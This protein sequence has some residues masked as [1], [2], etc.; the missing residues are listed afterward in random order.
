MTL[1]VANPAAPL[2]AAELPESGPHLLV[3]RPVSF[4]LLDLPGN[5]T[6]F[7]TESSYVLFAR[8]REASERREHVMAFTQDGRVM[9]TDSH[10]ALNSYLRSSRVGRMGLP[11]NRGLGV[12]RYAW[13]D[14]CRHLGIQFL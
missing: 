6:P 1:L 3:I 10:I 8:L 9:D 2:P 4:L 5:R 12:H 14:L 11:Y 13:T 7:K